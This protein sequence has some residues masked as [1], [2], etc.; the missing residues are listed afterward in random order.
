MA[1]K[2]KTEG[3]LGNPDYVAFGSEQHAATLGLEKASPE[4]IEQ[5]EKAGFGVVEG[6]Q[7]ADPLPFMQQDPTGRMEQR[8]LRSRVT[9]LHSKPTVPENAPPMF[10]PAVIDGGVPD[11]RNR[12]LRGEPLV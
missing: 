8:V 9:A 5:A 6:Y 4:D 3:P 1:T 11:M 7:L 2:R 12:A 10:V